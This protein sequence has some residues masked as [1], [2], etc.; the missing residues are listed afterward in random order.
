M[1][2]LAVVLGMILVAAGARILPHPPNFTPVGAMALFGGA[3]LGRRGLALAIP[4]IA[5]LLGDLALAL[6]HGDLSIAF[7]PLVPAVYGSV[8]LI[9][10]IGIAIGPGRPVTFVALGA[11]AGSVAFFVLTN[12]A[13]WLVFSTYAR[14]WEGLIECYV[15]ALPY[16]R[17]TLLGDAFYAALLFG[18]LSAVERTVPSVRDWAHAGPAW[19]RV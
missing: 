5:M 19:R 18:S 3:C 6:R 4:I 12:L 13:N 7:H 2:R 10:C 8:A 9:A 16:F 14:S 17:N 1:T 15:A 11:L